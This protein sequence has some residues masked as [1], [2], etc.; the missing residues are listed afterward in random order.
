MN[1][2]IGGMNRGNKRDFAGSNRK[3]AAVFSIF[4]GSEGRQC[5]ANFFS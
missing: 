3:I 2:R 4:R 1:L 5:G